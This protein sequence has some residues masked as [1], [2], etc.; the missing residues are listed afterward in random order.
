MTPQRANVLL[1]AIIGVLLVSLVLALAPEARRLGDRHQTTLHLKEMVLAMYGCADMH[2]GRI[3]P[4]FDQFKG[5]TYP[6]SVH[7][8]LLPFL[9]QDDL[10]KTFLKEG[11]GNAE[12]EVLVFQGLDDPSIVRLAGIQNFGANLRV[13]S[14]KG[15]ATLYDA[16]MPPLAA[17]EPG[18]AAIP[19]TFT[20]GTSN[21]I[22]FSTKMAECGRGGSRYSANPTSLF[23]AFIGQNPARESAAP[24]DPRATFLLQPGTDECL[25]SPLMAQ[26]FDPDRILVA[27]GDGSVRSVMATIDPGVWNQAMQPNDGRTLGGGVEPDN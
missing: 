11:Q 4:A 19:K 1:V 25:V 3:P 6:A 15:V 21:T 16:D 26:S 2:K 20:D 12:A 10:Y 13:F 8:H 14:D 27:L 17:V 9:K 18:T 22:V 5:I 24:D 23:A 7:V